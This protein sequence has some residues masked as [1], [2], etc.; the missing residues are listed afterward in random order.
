MSRYNYALSQFSSLGYGL[1]HERTLARPRYDD[2]DTSKVFLAAKDLA[3]NTYQTV[4]Q[5]WGDPKALPFLHLFLVFSYQYCHLRSGFY[6]H[7]DM[8]KVPW[9]LAALAKR[10]LPR[11]DP[12]TR[13]VPAILAMLHTASAQ[14]VRP[15]TDTDQPSSTNT[16][17]LADSKFPDWAIPLI[18]LLILGVVEVAGCVSK[19]RRKWYLIAMGASNLF[20]PW[21][22]DH[23]GVSPT[24]TIW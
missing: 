16:S 17:A 13:M 19:Q 20:F 21:L 8:K 7:D 22:V 9:R 23:D 12:L 15:S 5:R 6:P 24:L 11:M 10:G 18:S 2:D 14:P 4:A 3:L 1:R